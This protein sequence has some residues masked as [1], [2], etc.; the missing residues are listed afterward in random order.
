[1]ARQC[2]RRRC[3]RARGAFW[4]RRRSTTTVHENGRHLGGCP[5]PA[6]SYS[7]RRPRATATTTVTGGTGCFTDAT[8]TGNLTAHSSATDVNSASLDSTSTGTITLKKRPNCP[9]FQG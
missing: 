6:I 3:R 9:Y 5:S 2:A 8:G 4:Q 7:L 1:M